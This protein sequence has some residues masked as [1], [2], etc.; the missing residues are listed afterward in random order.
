MTGFKWFLKNLRHLC[1]LDERSLS[2]IR[3]IESGLKNHHERHNS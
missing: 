1:A 3:V 2:I